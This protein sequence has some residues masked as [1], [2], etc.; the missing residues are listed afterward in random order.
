LPIPPGAVSIVGNAFRRA[1]LVDFSPEQMRFLEFGRVV[2]TT[3]LRDTFGYQPRYT[4]RQAFDEWVTSA[5]LR[6]LVKREQVL[7]VERGV[8]NLAARGQAVLGGDP[9]RVPYPELVATG[10]GVGA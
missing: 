4:T 2:D 3:K 6:R 9:R 10:G 7:A 1:G 8:L 5:D